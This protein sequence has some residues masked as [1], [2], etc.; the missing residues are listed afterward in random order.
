[1]VQD[2]FHQQ[3][4]WQN[5]GILLHVFEREK[6][7]QDVAT[8]TVTF[9]RTHNRHEHTQLEKVLMPHA[10]ACHSTHSPS[11]RLLHPLVRRHRISL[12]RDMWIG[13]PHGSCEWIGNSS[14]PIEVAE[15]FVSVSK[16]MQY[17]YNI[18]TYSA[19]ASIPPPPLYGPRHDE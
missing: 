4:C 11:T 3:Y 15:F 5:Y 18:S 10:A 2:F 7:P 13:A 12:P 9:L 8:H 16:Y 19:W 17:V 6:P 1:M 14:P